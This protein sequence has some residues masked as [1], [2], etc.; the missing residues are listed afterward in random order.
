MS[1]LERYAQEINEVLAKYP[2]EHKRSAVMPI[3]Y[4]VQQDKG[5]ID[6]HDIQDIA[7]SLDL[8]ETE[9]VSLIGFYSLYH[10]EPGGRLRIQ[11]CV[12]LPCALRGADD[13]LQQLCDQLAI[14]PGGTTED[15]LV[16]VEPVMCLA[17]CDKAPVFQLQNENG[18][19]YQEN[20]DIG[21]TMALIDDYR[22]RRKKDT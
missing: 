17:A 6:R 4:I 1:L 14:E 9:I 11:V 18:I 20:M 22:Q 12:D 8:E 15:G 7:T 13:F 10:S 5:Y 21:K 3:L 16:T 2:P 19:E